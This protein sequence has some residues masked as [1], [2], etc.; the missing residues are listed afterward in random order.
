M[1][2]YKGGFINNEEDEKDINKLNLE[3]EKTIKSIS[4]HLNLKSKITKFRFIILQNLV[5]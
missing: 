5:K 2:N 1:Q 4:V 3:V